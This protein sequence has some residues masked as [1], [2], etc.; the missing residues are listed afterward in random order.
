MDRLAS[1]EVLIAIVDYGGFAR[2]AE[3]L[4]MSPTMVSTH[5]A[6]LEDRLGTRLIHRSTRRFALTPQGRLYV[7][8]TRAILESLREADE[9]VRRGAS[10]P[11]GRVAIDA[12]GAIGLR[13]VVPAL[14]RLRALHPRVA[15]DLSV[16]DR[17][18]IYRPEG[19]DI[20]IRVGDPPEGKGEVTTLGQTPYVQVASPDYITRRGE[21]A[22]PD[23]LH[24][25]DTILYAATDRPAGQWRF[26]QRGEHRTMRLR[27]VATFNHGDAL[28]AAASAGM[29]IAQTLEMLVAPELAAGRLVPI[30]GQWNRECVDIQLFVPQD[31]AARAAVQAVAAFLRDEPSWCIRPEPD[32]G[33]DE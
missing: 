16:G 1:L 19:F 20:L 32:R 7:D 15:I 31:R 10:G 25:H 24:D 2:A 9:A 28:A 29:G 11:S 8:D 33:S 27:S 14:P 4:G 3:R 30:L 22:S 12:P 6:R 5:L 18:T 21:P 26:S 13:F 17:S 23:E